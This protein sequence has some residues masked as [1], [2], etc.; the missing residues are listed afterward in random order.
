MEKAKQPF[1][2]LESYETGYKKGKL[3][4]TM[5]GVNISMRIFNAWLDTAYEITSNK[6]EFYKFIKDTFEL[7]GGTNY[8]KSREKEERFCEGIEKAEAS[9]TTL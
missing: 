6:D 3:E 1:E 5:E 2:G 4:G 7:N 9:R 8:D